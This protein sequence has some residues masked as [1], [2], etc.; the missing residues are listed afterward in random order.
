[1][2]AKLAQEAGDGAAAATLLAQTVDVTPDMAH[3]L[4]VELRK[5]VVWLG[6]SERPCKGWA[7]GIG[8]HGTAFWPLQTGS[9]VVQPVW[10]R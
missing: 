9:I 4:V 2:Q 6:C 1:M 10:A 8:C 5:Q 3:Q 7:C